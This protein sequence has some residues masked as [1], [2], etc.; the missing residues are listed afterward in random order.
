MPQIKRR[1]RGGNRGIN[2]SMPVSKLLCSKLVK[3][4]EVACVS[5]LRKKK[6]FEEEREPDDNAVA[7]IPKEGA[8]IA[9]ANEARQTVGD[10]HHCRW[11]LE[12]ESAPGFGGKAALLE[13][14]EAT[15]GSWGPAGHIRKS[16]A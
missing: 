8:G 9:G 1:R 12:G 15:D 3:E 2:S 14:G 11:G 5:F 4:G 13:G 16:S 7:L 6:N 10:K